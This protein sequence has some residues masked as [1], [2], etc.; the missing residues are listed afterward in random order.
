MSNLLADREFQLQESSWKNPPYP[1]CSLA[2]GRKQ[3]GTLM[4]V[5]TVLE[6]FLMDS[7]RD[8]YRR[9]PRASINVDIMVNRLHGFSH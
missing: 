1:G 2:R 5:Y 7:P 8:Q 4:H 3:T 6:S 9:Q